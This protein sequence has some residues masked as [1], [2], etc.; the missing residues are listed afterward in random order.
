MKSVIEEAWEGRA[1]LNPANAPRALRDALEEAI[2]GLDAGRLRVA[3][4]TS[5]GWITHQW[6]K[7]AVLL[8]FRLED[9]QVIEG[10]QARYFDK[11]P[12]KFAAALP[13]IRDPLKTERPE[14]GFYLWMRTPVDD[15]EFARRLHQ[16]YNVL[17]LPGSFLAREAH[18]VNPGQGF[19]RIA[20]VAAPH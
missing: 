10:G 3:E 9:N 5:A 14:G 17:V 16:Q 20:L 4:K 15:G 11:V 7:K 8:S 18:A 19:V 2:A 12:S 1:S 13:L 6:I